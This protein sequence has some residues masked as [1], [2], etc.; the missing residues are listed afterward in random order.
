MS[1]QCRAQTTCPPLCCP[2][3][4]SSSLSCR[5]PRGHHSEPAGRD[6][7]SHFSARSS[8]CVSIFPL[9]NA[10]FGILSRCK[11]RLFPALVLVGTLGNR[12]FF[13]LV[14]L[15]KVLALIPRF[16]VEGILHC[17]QRTRSTARV[18]V[19]VCGCETERERVKMTGCRNDRQSL[20]HGL[21]QT[22]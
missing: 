4:L 14:S 10:A 6:R 3:S 15:L 1:R 9:S 19:C 8:P 5:D 20:A 18:C 21:L 17:Y 2:P 12:L 16:R 11:T 22:G 13:S 7:H